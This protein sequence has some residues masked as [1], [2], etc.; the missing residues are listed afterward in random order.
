MRK[1]KKR[2]KERKGR[3]KKEKEA[4]IIHKVVLHAGNQLLRS[5]YTARKAGLL[6]LG[7]SRG[8][9]PHHRVMYSIT[10]FY[11]LNGRRAQ[12]LTPRLLW[13]Q[14]QIFQILP[15]VPWGGGVPQSPKI[16]ICNQ[17]MLN[18]HFHFHKSSRKQWSSLEVSSFSQTRKYPL[19]FLI[20]S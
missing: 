3:K 13:E 19:V 7:M 1:G 16:S 5:S 2:R 12:T 9:P 15:C 6:T 20:T 11:P 14:S 8:Y 4:T 18:I 17:S 10:G